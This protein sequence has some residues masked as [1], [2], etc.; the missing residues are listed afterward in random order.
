MTAMASASAVYEVQLNGVVDEDGIV[1]LAVGAGNVIAVVVTAQDGESSRTYSVT[2]TRA[3]SPDAT[4]SALSLSGGDVD[5]GVCVGDDG[6]HGVGG[7]RGNG[8]H[9]DGVGERR[10]C[11]RGGE[12]Q[13]GCG[14]GRCSGFGGGRWQRDCRRSNRGGW[15][16]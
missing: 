7:T 8:D 1:G 16:D 2:V 13:R 5:A 14:P 15:A 4:L 12:G 10:Q 3:G 6:V 9:G 11:Q